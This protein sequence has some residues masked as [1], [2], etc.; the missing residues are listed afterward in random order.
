[1]SRTISRSVLFF[2]SGH[3]ALCTVPDHDN[4]FYCNDHNCTDG[5]ASDANCPESYP[6]CGAVQP[7]R[8]GCGSDTDCKVVYIQP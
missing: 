2:A 8:C 1:M 5:C 6:V 3:D 7:H 4:C